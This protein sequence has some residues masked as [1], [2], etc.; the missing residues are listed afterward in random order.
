MWLQANVSSLSTASTCGRLAV[1][2][3][4]KQ[5]SNFDKEAYEIRQYEPLKNRSV[6]A[7]VRAANHSDATV[8]GI[9]AHD[10]MQWVLESTQSN[11]TDRISE[12]KKC[13]TQI[14]NSDF[15]HPLTQEYVKE[16]MPSSVHDARIQAIVDRSYGLIRTW[17][18]FQS[19]IEI[20]SIHTERPLA[21]QLSSYDGSEVFLLARAD[22]IVESNIG[23]L[24]IEFKTGDS[25]KHSEWI[26]QL[27]LY[28]AICED[29]ISRL[30]IIHP[31]G[32]FIQS[33]SGI[34]LPEFSE[35][36]EE[37]SAG[38]HCNSCIFKKKNDCT[39]YLEWN[40]NQMTSI[41]H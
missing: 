28:A 34:I 30:V 6:G 14:T 24:I 12:L 5:H 8:A 41:L 39:T 37:E 15:S 40:Q 27:E 16:L 22:A 1:S 21:K 19:R 20:K 38:E 23:T 36:D 31:N 29:K 11:Q 4:K 18:K 9:V 10:F 33:P 26:H 13:L 35:I 3:L 25:D 2:K 32:G 7:I 17:E